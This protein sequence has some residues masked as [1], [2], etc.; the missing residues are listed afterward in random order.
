MGILT[1]FQKEFK[2]IKQKAEKPLDLDVSIFCENVLGYKTKSDAQKI[3]AMLELDCTLYT[4]LGKDSTIS[5][6]K[7]VKK[8]SRV[9]YRS[10]KTINKPLGDSFL[11]HMDRDD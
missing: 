4:L 1:L 7:H 3:D 9:I 5:D 10:I 11:T 8:M 2:K 6:K